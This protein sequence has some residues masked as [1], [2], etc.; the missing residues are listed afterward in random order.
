V[1][2]SSLLAVIIMCGACGDNRVPSADGAVVPVFRNPVSLPDDELALRALQILGADVPAAQ[3]ASCNTCHGLTRDRLQYWRRLSD[4]AFATCFTDLAVTSPESARS[5]LDCMRA[6][7]MVPGSDFDTRKLGVFSTASHLPWFAYT[8]ERAYGADALSQLAAFQQLAGMPRAGLGSLSQ[9]DFD[10]VAE[11]FLRGLPS[12]DSTLVGPSPPA[13]CSSSITSDVGTHVTAMA[14]QGWKA[15]NAQAGM[16]M[17]WCGAAADPHD[18]MQNLPERTEWEVPGHGVVRVLL[19]STYTT[20]FWTRSSPD[21]RFVAYGVA[22]VEGSYVWDLQR[23]ALIPIGAEFDPA[24]FPDGSGFAFQGSPRNTC[25]ESVLTSNPAAIT[26]SEPGCRDITGLGLYEHLGRLA[27]ADY[28]ASDGLFVA[29]DGGK[30][31]TTT[32]PAAA[33]V[34][35]SKTGFTPMLFDGTGY[36]QRARVSVATPFEG[37]PVLSPSA[38]LVLT[39]LAGQGD[40]LLGYVLRRVDSTFN[41]ST[42]AIDAPQIARYC[43][44]GGKPGFS[45][46]ERWI[47][48][49]HYESNGSANLYLV[50]LLVGDPVR[51]TAMAPGQY[52]LYPHFRSDGWI[53]AQIRD[54]NTGHELTIALDAAL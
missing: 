12:L 49:H 5:M 14:T 11:W 4:T 32:D 26:M 52:A 10:I 15:L 24:F 33:F 29:D 21:G 23:G 46:D 42:Y 22:D 48:F 51:I 19:D 17:L 16:E 53:Y 30:L 6:M 44:T 34:A 31:A 35:S 3:T 38:K 47:V 41:G 54:A 13:T 18:C 25:P 7:P 9:D 40:Q 1:R 20:S 50:D 45:Y 2:C 43:F 39:R 36:V 8:F 37:D 28:F 27:G